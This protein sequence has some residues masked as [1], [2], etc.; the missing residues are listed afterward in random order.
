MD[1]RLPEEGS[2]RGEIILKQKALR[3]THVGIFRHLK[4]DGVLIDVEITAS[5]LPFDGH[6]SGTG[7]GQRRHRPPRDRTRAGAPS[8]RE[9]AGT[10]HRLLVTDAPQ[11]VVNELCAR[12]HGLS[13]LRRVLQLP[14]RRRVRPPALNACAGIPSTAATIE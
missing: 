1:I 7:A 4:K 14:R 2:R 10:A 13:G 6:P 5:S 12:G 8:R 9:I 3:E 11:C